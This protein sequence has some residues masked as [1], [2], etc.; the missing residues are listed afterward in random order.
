MWHF[1]PP[2]V[3][4]RNRHLLKMSMLAQEQSWDSLYAMRFRSVSKFLDGKHEI[5]LSSA[6]LWILPQCSIPHS[7]LLPELIFTEIIFQILYCLYEIAIHSHF[8]VFDLPT[9]INLWNLYYF[10]LAWN[11]VVSGLFDCLKNAG[12]SENYRFMVDYEYQAKK[13]EIYELKYIVLEIYVLRYLSDFTKYL[14]SVNTNSA[15]LQVLQ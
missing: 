13:K 11:W 14:L 3:V 4:L 12:M 1:L 2:F 7:S 15:V 6:Q 8:F 9:H 10:F 5:M